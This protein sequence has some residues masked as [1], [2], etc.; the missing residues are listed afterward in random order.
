MDI[1]ARTARSVRHHR[2]QVSSP[3]SDHNGRSRQG[4]ISKKR[5]DPHDRK[6]G[7]PYFLWLLVEFCL[8][9]LIFLMALL[10]KGCQWTGERQRLSLLFIEDKIVRLSGNFGLNVRIRYEHCFSDE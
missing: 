6:A 1:D 3:C 4:F 8:K 9:V 2:I 5:Y 7:G 10:D